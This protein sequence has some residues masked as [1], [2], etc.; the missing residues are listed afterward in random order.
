[1]TIFA[2]AERYARDNSLGLWGEETHT[3]ESP[4]DGSAPAY[5]PIV[6]IT[7]TGTKYHRDGCRYL[8]ESKIAIRLSEA[9]I[10]GYEPCSVCWP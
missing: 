3:V 8:S 2:E 7:D 9:I 5:D 1:M 4:S 6:Y 10:R